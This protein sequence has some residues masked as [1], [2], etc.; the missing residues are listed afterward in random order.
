MDA[1]S[2]IKQF[3]HVGITVADLGLVTA[4]FVDLGLEL[5]G[6]TF[7]EGE[8]VDAVAGSVLRSTASTRSSTGWPRRDTG[9]S[10]RSVSTRTPGSWRTYVGRR[11]SSSRPPSGS[12]D[13][14]WF[15]TVATHR[16]G[17]Q[18]AAPRTMIWVELSLA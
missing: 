10:A 2:R 11:V 9:W 7:L 16:L 15:R 4:F 5:E 3:D 17:K 13:A 12:A 1:T 6:R 14:N 8:F 18:A